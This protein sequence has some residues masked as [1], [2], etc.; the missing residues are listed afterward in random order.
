MAANRIPLPMG[1]EGLSA[2]PKTQERLKNLFLTS[3]QAKVL[4]IRPGIDKIIEGFGRCRASGLFRN[5]PEVEEI[6][7]E[8][9]YMVSG[10]RLIRIRIVNNLPKR[11]LSLNDVAI[12]DLGS[13]PGA[14]ECVLVPGFSKLL[15]LE[16]GGRAY[17]Y[18]HAGG[19]IPFGESSLPSDES[20]YRASLHAVY[21]AGRWVYAPLD[22]EP[23]FWSELEEQG[24]PEVILG[25]NFADAEAFPD[26]IKTVQQLKG[27]IYAGG[28]RSWQRFRFDPVLDTYRPYIGEESK[29]GFIGGLVNYG[30]NFAF[31]G[32]GPEGDINIFEMRGQPFPI[33]NDFI[34]EFINSEYSA[35]ELGSMTATSF[36]WK[37]TTI[38]AF[39]FPRHT[40]VYYGGWAFWQSGLSGQSVINWDINYTQSAYG[41]IWT[42]DRNSFNIG[43]FIDRGHEYGEDIE[44]LLRT[45]ID[46]TTESFFVI[47][48][49]TARVSMGKSLGGKESRIALSLSRDGVLFGQNMYKTLAATGHYNAQLR[50]GSPLMKAYDSVSILFTGYGSVVMN[51]DGVF[52]E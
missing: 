3:G 1:N 4:A 18:T 7:E 32:T 16:V 12:D 29:V 48:R 11:V 23:F 17:T 45:F 31:V 33:S 26:P 51:F 21:D 6:G 9:L 34:S 8:E 52:Y 19:L 20:N 27:S 43:I 25:S 28:T 44:W 37:K 5:N 30:E 14:G 2:S 46:S 50:W 24:G 40:L 38:L 35:I 36:E 42:G 49:I 39:R 47:N 13:I 22:G 10:Q 15:V 41:Y